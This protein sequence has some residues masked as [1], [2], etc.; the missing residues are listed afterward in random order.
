MNSKRLRM[1]LLGLLG[2][3]CVLFIAVCFIGLS[4]L[5]KKSQ[6]MVGFKLQSKVLDDQ[7]NTLAQAK[8]QVETYSYIKNVAAEVIPEDK[9]QAQAVLEIFQIANQSGI[10][11]QS[12][13]FPTSTLGAGAAA[14][15]SATSSIISQATPVAGIKGLYSIQMTITPETGPEVPASQ[16]VTYPKI[17]DFLNR[18]EHN[19][20]TAQ[21]TQFNVQPQGGANGATASSITFSLTVNLFIKP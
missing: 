9:D 21:I 3:S 17:L 13:T 10:A 6:E 8:K 5:S 7:I 2:G 14:S 15:T 1:I 4:T 11:I 12:L 16:Q 19:Q 20:R 18:I